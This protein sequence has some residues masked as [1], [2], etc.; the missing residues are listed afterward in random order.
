MI[1]I[2]KEHNIKIEQIFVYAEY[3]QQNWT[4]NQRFVNLI[5]Y[6]FA[7]FVFHFLILN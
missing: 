7:H 5:D 6:M 1:I 4:N 2:E 3:E